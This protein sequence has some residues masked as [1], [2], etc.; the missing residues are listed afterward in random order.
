MG[1]S[2]DALVDPSKGHNSPGLDQVEIRCH[3]THFIQATHLGGRRRRSW[4]I[5]YCLSK[6]INRKL[7]CKQAA[8]ALIRD[9]G[10][11]R[12]GDLTSSSTV[13]PPIPLLTSHVCHS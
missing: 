4:A 5:I 9:T 12:G 7:V 10:V 3:S 13:S 8:G 2:I 6:L 11:K 1:V